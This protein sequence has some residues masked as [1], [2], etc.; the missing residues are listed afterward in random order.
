MTLFSFL[1]FIFFISHIFF[2]ERSFWK[3]FSLKNQI[4]IAKKEYNLLLND[5]NKTLLEI[6]LL[7][8]KNLDPDLI[9][10]ISHKQ[11]GLIQSDQIVIDIT[12]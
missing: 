7:R 8:D 2:G 3:I 1:I 4:S 10:E 5:K 11:L 9:P 6:N 12:K